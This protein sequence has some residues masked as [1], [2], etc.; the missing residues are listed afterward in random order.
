MKINVAQIRLD[1]FPQHVGVMF[2][3]GK[4]FGIS[5]LGGMLF[6]RNSQTISFA[7][8]NTLAE[9]HQNKE[10]FEVV[11]HDVFEFLN[12]ITY[13]CFV[14]VVSVPSLEDVASYLKGDILDFW[15]HMNDDK[16][17]KDQLHKF[18]ELAA[19]FK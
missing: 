3:L 1:K 16:E 18:F 10:L 5:N 6:I 9:V 7:E 11:K 4:E 2:A 17:F 13:S 14:A 15:T 8:A 19:K 12:V